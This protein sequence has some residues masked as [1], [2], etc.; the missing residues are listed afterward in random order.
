MVVAFG[1]VEAGATSDAC[2]GVTVRR[3]SAKEL[4]SQEI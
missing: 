2:G 3:T 4:L 1:D